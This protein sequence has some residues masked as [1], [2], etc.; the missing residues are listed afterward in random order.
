MLR[1]SR[2]RVGLIQSDRRQHGHQMVCAKRPMNLIRE[3]QLGAGLPHDAEKQMLIL[4]P[5]LS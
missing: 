4:P 3:Y 5:S 2:Q 1:H